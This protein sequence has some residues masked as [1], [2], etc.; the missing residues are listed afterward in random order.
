MVKKLELF[1]PQEVAGSVERFTNSQRTR[2]ARSLRPSWRLEVDLQREVIGVSAGT[3]AHLLHA[4]TCPQSVVER[5]A[6]RIGDEV[7]CVE[8]VALSRPIWPH[9]EHRGTQRQV[10]RGNALVVPHRKAIDEN[11]TVHWRI[12]AVLPAVCESIDQQPSRDPQRRSSDFGRALRAIS[13]T[14]KSLSK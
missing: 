13:M 6:Q 3:A 10:T 14:F 11:G 1:R 9:E 5:V 7:K 4:A 2:L 12:L 8:E